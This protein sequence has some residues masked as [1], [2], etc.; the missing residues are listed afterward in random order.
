MGLQQDNVSSHD[1]QQQS[2]TDAD[3]DAACLRLL[4][5]G[6]HSEFCFKLE[7]I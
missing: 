5:A 4:T 1:E 3:A 7:S 2:L 6:S